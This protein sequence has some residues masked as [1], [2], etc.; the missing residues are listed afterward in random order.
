[1]L[2]L[3][4]NTLFDDMVKK[5]E[6][7]P[8]LKRTFYAILFRGEKFVFNTDNRVLDIGRMFGMIKSHDGA[9]AI[10]NRI[11]E[12]RLYNLFLSEEMLSGQLLRGSQNPRHEADGHHH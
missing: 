5:L 4:S 7:F 3:E 2:L 10:A 12:T 1:M 9:V 8:E 6:D 11:F